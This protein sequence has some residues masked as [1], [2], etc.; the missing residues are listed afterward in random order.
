MWPAQALPQKSLKSPISFTPG[1][2]PVTQ[3]P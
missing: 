2:S 1:F 3:E